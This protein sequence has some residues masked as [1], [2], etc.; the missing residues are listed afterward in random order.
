MSLRRISLCSLR[1]STSAR[2]LKSGISAATRTGQPVVS[3]CAIGPMAERPSRAAAR[4][5]PG[6]M[7]DA[8]TAPVPVIRILRRGMLYAAPVTSSGWRS[9]TQLFEPPN[10]NELDKVIRTR[11]C[12]RRDDK[13]QIAVRVALAQVRIDRQLAVSNR[14][15]AHHDL[16][17]AGRRDQMAHRALGRADGDVGAP[18]PRTPCGSRRSRSCRSCRSMCRAH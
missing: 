2:G 9:A 18:C 10:P 6:S 15:R 17:G 16:D 3:H 14:Q 4:I 5:A 13:I 1:S 7:P 8:H 11:R 12:G